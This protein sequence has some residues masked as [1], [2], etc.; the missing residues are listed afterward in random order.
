[1]ILYAKLIENGQIV[2]L[3][4]DGETISRIEPFT[5]DQKWKKSILTFTKGL[6][7]ELT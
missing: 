5:T 2:T 3:H 1:M 4:I 7:I 6:K